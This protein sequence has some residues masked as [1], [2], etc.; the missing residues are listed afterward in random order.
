M[1]LKTIITYLGL[2]VILV[3]WGVTWANQNAKIN[4]N[5]S[6]IETLDMS[7]LEPARSVAPNLASSSEISRAERVVVPSSNIDKARLAVPG[8]PNWSAA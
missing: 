6:D 7:T 4:S 2:A 5:T 3:G 1:K 8:S